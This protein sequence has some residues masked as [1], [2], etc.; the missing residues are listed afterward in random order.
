MNNYLIQIMT[1]FRNLTLNSVGA[2][3]TLYDLLQDKD[4]EAALRMMQER[5]TEVDNALKEYNPQT[6]EVMSRPNK[7]RKN[8]T[9]YITEKLPRTRQ[10]YINDI[11]LFFLLGN[12]IIWKKQGGDDKAY[13]MFTAFLKEQH[14]NSRIRQAKRLAGAET[15]SA[16]IF[17]IYRDVDTN[18]QR[19]KL[20]VLARSTG[21]KLRPLFDQY[22]NMTAFAYG[23]TTKENGRN[24][25]HWDFQ[26]S[27]ILAY[28]KRAALG[29]D[30]EIYPNPTEKINAIYFQQPKAWD[31]AEPRIAREEMLDSKTGDTNN[32][33]SD[34]IAAATADVVDNLIDPDKPGKL[35]QLSSGNSR[36]EYINP[37]QSSVTRDAEKNDLHKSILFDTYTPD[38]DT[39]SMR[40]FGSLSGV[41]IR[42][43]FI[44][45]YIK[46]DMRR[47]IYDELIGR[48]RNIVLA[49]LT[50]QNPD[51]ASK[52][53]EL[54]IDFEFAEPFA[55]D[56]QAQWGA[57]IQLYTAGLISLDHAVEMLAICETPDAEIERI[58]KDAAE[59]AALMNPQQESA[60]TPAQ[61]PQK[62][63][64]EEPPMKPNLQTP[65]RT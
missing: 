21:Y 14:F 61:T 64:K 42:N 36:F 30:V 1:Y 19:V 48:F 49:I 40:G 31:G 44:L 43:T 12:P 15:E 23:Y 59:K 58:K 7:Y 13:E 6:H 53:N 27:K 63:E 62:V 35:I 54:K 37:P 29:W 57:I 65:L 47:E 33:F 20:N 16:L 18:E 8:D 34:P 32:Y 2:H 22:G 10:R 50:F 26:T 5:D 4:V 25:Q 52:F 3:R 56:R 46:R 17:H 9:P 51:M 38:F 41:A 55:D 24:I 28:C 11:E 45:G 60:Q 39:D